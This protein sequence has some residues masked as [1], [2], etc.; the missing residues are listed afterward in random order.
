MYNIKGLKIFRNKKSEKN[1]KKGVDK[2]GM[3]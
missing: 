3:R 2:R 1:F